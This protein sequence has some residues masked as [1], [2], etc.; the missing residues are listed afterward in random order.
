M[1]VAM[2]RGNGSDDRQQ[3]DEWNIAQKAMININTRCYEGKSESGT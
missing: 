2:R 1:W 3:T